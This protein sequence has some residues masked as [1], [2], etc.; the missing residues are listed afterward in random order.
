MAEV[1]DGGFAGL[2]RLSLQPRNLIGLKSSADTKR[3][4][5]TFSAGAASLFQ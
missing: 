2:F 3:G 4:F 1:F 5:R